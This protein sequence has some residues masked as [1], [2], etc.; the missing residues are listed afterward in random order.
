METSLIQDPNIPLYRYSR[1]CAVGLG[2]KL[3]VVKG[4]DQIISVLQ[5]TDWCEMSVTF[6]WLILWDSVFVFLYCHLV[7]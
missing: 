5:G 4:T 1:A 3:R 6:T 7:S 2:T